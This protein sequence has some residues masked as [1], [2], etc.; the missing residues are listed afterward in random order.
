MKTALFVDFDNIFLSLRSEGGEPAALRFANDPARWIRWLEATLLRHDEDEAAQRKRRILVRTCYLNP[1][2]HGRFRSAFT[3]AAFRVVDCPSVTS[4]GKN[5]ADIHMVMDILDTLASPTHFDEFIILSGDADFRPVLLRLRAHDRRTVLLTVGPSSAA[6]EG[7]SDYVIR[8]EDFLEKALG[9]RTG[10]QSTE[11]PAVAPRVVP[12]PARPVASRTTQLDGAPQP[13]SPPR[14]SISAP[15]SVDALRDAVGEE[16]RA[17]VAKSQQPVPLAK[18]AQQ[19]DGVFGDFLRD[20]NWLGMGTFK[21]A[22]ESFADQGIAV[23][24]LV[25]GLVYDPARHE[26]PSG[27]AD[28]DEVSGV[29]ERVSRQTGAPRRTTEEYACLFDALD[30]VL[31]STPYHLVGTSKAVRDACNE[32]GH[33]V[34]RADINFVLKGIGYRRPSLLQ[35]EPA[36][37]DPETLARTFCDNVLALAE[38]LGLELTDDERAEVVTWITGSAEGEGANKRGEDEEG[39]SE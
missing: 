8:S 7:A 38:N 36:Q 25:S 1:S 29:I 39:E 33:P 9:F 14:E 2:R 11:V 34:A 6:Y 19:L 5:S 22:I 30:A 35:G 37:R 10:A 28:D 18:L 13:V 27:A 24:P 12:A 4:M 17:I 16:V 21:R 15:M 23:S 20:S 31:K 32:R 26:L 3:A